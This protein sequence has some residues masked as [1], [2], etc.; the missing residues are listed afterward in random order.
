MSIQRR[1]YADVR[2]AFKVHIG[3]VLS[4]HLLFHHEVKTT[5]SPEMISV[6]RP[7]AD[8]YN[9]AHVIVLT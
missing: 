7:C 4:A 5:L 2:C 3:L 9:E 1:H 6:T 8:H